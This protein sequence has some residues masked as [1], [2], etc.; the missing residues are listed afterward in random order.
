MFCGRRTGDGQDGFSGRDISGWVQAARNASVNWPEEAGDAEVRE[1]IRRLLLGAEGLKGRT[2]EDLRWLTERVFLALRRDLY[3]LEKY[4][5]DPSVTEIMVNG[6]DKIFIEK[7]GQMLRTDL[8]FEDRETLVSVI[9]RLAANVDREINEV[10]PI[11]DARTEEG[12]RVNAVYQNVALE[13]PI[14]TIRKLPESAYTMEDLVR[15]GTLTEECAA[16][17][18][19]FIRT[20]MNVMDKAYPNPLD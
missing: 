19:K 4:S 12:Y 1:E 10:H 9:R 8:F 11:V 20:H 18:M 14:L 3:F 2:P 6:P 16:F 13:G 15:F 17:L 5:K 7:D